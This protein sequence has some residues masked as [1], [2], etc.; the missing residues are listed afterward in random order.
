MNLVLLESQG[1]VQLLKNIFWK[2]E[3]L[4]LKE[5]NMEIFNCLFKIDTACKI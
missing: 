3:K 1:R 2:N 4:K 5:M